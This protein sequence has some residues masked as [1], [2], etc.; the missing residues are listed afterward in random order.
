MSSH[1]QDLRILVVE[2]DADSAFLLKF[3]LEEQ[4]AEVLVA[5]TIAAAITALSQFNPDLLTTDYRLP[6]GDGR[7][8]VAAVQTLTQA[9]DRP[10]AIVAITGSVTQLEEKQVVAEGFQALLSKPISPDQVI[11]TIVT[12]L[13]PKA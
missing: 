4:G 6:D 7:S 2:D 11:E 3:I 1:L 10:I 5:G 8:L 9:N 12:L 13:Q